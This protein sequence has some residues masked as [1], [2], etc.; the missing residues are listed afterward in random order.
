MLEK[1]VPRVKN[2]AAVNA[3]VLADARIAPAALGGADRSGTVLGRRPRRASGVLLLPPRA[4]RK[5]IIGLES[6]PGLPA[7]RVEEA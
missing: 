1:L 6:T 4:S 2:A 7:T 5:R 3:S